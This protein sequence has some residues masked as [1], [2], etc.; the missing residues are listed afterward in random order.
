MFIISNLFINSFFM[1]FL[2]EEEVY[3]QGRVNE[4]S[5]DGG[6]F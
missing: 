1:S 2:I 6:A 3:M 5:K 4:L